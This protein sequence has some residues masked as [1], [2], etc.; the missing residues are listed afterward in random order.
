M[1][2]AQQALCIHKV[3]QI[4]DNG[5]ILWLCLIFIHC[6]I[7]IVISSYVWGEREFDEIAPLS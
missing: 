2:R 7:C 1:P 3:I 4:S 6:T 5:N